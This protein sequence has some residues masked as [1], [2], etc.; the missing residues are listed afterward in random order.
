MLW[1]CLLGI[2]TALTIVLRRV[3]R[4]QTPLNNQLYSKNVAIEHAQTGVASVRADGTFESANQSFA[5]ALNVAERDLIGQEWYKMFPPQEH[6]RVREAFAQTLLAG[7]TSLDV[8]GARPDASTVWLNVRLVAV[9]D[10][11]MRFVGH[12]CLIEDHSREHEL[13][14]RLSELNAAKPEL[15][16]LERLR[17]TLRSPQKS[18]RPAMV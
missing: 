8:N 17:V 7:V 12:H 4:R 9:H 2:V 1:L 13:E 10:R 3:L 15:T 11:K 18:T 6:R 5:K 16:A 14:R